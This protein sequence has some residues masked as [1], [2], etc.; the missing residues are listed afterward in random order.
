MPKKLVQQFTSWSFTR[1]NDWE[2]CPFRAKK[3]YLDKVQEPEGP[4]LQRGKTIEEEIYGFIFAKAKDKLKKVLPESGARFD[5]ELKKLQKIARSILNNRELAFDKD[6]N[7][8]DWK[9]WDRAW[10]RIKMD[11]LWL[12]SFDDPFILPK[13]KK[14]SVIRSVDIKTGKVYE[15]KVDQID[16]Y[17]VGALCSAPTLFPSANMVGSQLWY[18]DQ[19]ETRPDETWSTLTITD[20]PKEKKRWEK[21]VRPMLMDQAFIPKPSFKCKYCHLQKDKGGPCPY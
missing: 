16:L 5:I 9:D 4:A 17:N 14:D 15:D 6:W 10:V 7:P 8:C 11:L 3:K 2:S 13:S 21:R 12:S 18:L 1:L 20:L 19:G